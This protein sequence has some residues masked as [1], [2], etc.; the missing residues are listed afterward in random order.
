MMNQ[1]IFHKTNIILLII[2]VFA[3]AILSIDT[4]IAQE[5][6]E[7]QDGNT[8]NIKLFYLGPDGNTY[9]PETRTIT[10]YGNTVDQVK[11]TLM[12]L[13]RG[14]MTNLIPT[15]PQGTDI[16]EVFID[17]KRCAYVDFSRAISQNH[18]G[19][20]TGE[21]ATIA[22]VV[23][24]LTENFPKDINKVMILIDGREARTI[25]GHIDI[26]KPIFPF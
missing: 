24:T 12:E 9:L 20:T 11:I 7:T 5:A 15:I 19:G 10:K 21:L 14:P 25:A 2:C 26:T 17:G 22:S 3:I 13:I 6:D 4:M 8:M 23:N 18:I 16:R 1:K